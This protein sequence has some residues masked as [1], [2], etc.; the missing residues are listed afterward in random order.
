MWSS[1]AYTEPSTSTTL[2]LLSYLFLLNI[3][4]WIAQRLIGAALIGQILIGIIYGTPLSGWLSETIQAALVD[5]GY[6]GLL[7]VVFE[8]APSFVHLC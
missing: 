3:F 4:G 2:I 8:G 7:L 6:V 5:V 1:F